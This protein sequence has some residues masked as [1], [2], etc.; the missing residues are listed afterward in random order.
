M[1][2]SFVERT[3]ALTPAER[4]ILKY[5]I[6]GREIAEI[7]GLAFISI[8]TVRKHNKNI[9]RKLAVS[10]KEELLL[11]IDLLRRSNR[12]VEIENLTD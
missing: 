7:P 11:Y 9:Y 4:N 3:A 10:T 2:D 5:Y 8:H 6:N 1:L 12:L